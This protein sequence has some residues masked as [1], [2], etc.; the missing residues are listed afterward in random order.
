[1]R[2]VIEPRPGG[3]AQQV[4]GPKIPGIEHDAR[5][6]FRCER[7]VEQP[8][9]LPAGAPDGLVDIRVAGDHDV[10]GEHAVRRNTIRGECDRWHGEKTD[11]GRDDCWP[12]PAG[13][14][15]PNA[16][17]WPVRLGTALRE[18]HQAASR[19]ARAAR[20]GPRLAAPSGRTQRKR[21][22]TTA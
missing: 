4:S 7:G 5:Q 16:A 11:P 6:G 3:P 8:G 13:R 2:E 19:A 18:R 15:R 10:S 17:A 9:A 22:I 12:S 1:P 21:L 20:G 14:L